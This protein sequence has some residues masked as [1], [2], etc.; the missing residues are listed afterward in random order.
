MTQHNIR[1]T[2]H[3]ATS[4]LFYLVL[5]TGLSMALN[6]CAYDRFSNRSPAWA[7]TLGG[8][9][10]AIKTSDNVPPVDTKQTQ[11]PTDP[12]PPDPAF[13]K[14]GSDVLIK[15]APKVADARPQQDGDV[16]LNFQNANLLEVIK[17][18]LGDM[19]EVNYT[20]DPTIQGTVS[21]QT[22][23][24]LHRDD[25]IPTLEMLL[26]MNNAALI[27]VD[28]AFR[29]VPLAN[30]FA[31]VRSPQLGDSGLAL[32]TGYSVRV[33]PLRY[34]AAEE[35]AQILNPFVTGN[36]QLLRVDTARNMLILAGT[37]ADMERLLETVNVFDVDRMSGMSVA[38]FTPDFVDAKTLA[39]DLDALLADPK[40]GLMAGLVRFIVVERL[41]GLMVV[42]PRAEY[43]ARVREWV[44]RLD[45]NTGDA[46]PRLFIYRVQNGKATD[47]A[48]VLSGLFEGADEQREPVSLAPGSTPTTVGSDIPTVGAS[49]V[50]NTSPDVVDPTALP[51]NQPP[52]AT[53]PPGSPSGSGIRFNQNQRV[54][55][56]ADEANN[57]LLILARGSE[58]RQILTALKQLDVAPMQVLIEVTI[59]EV[60]LTDNLAYGVEWFFKNG[61]GSKTGEGTLDLGTLGLNDSQLGFTYVVRD[62]I[63]DP[64]AI[65]NLLATE[66]NLSVISSP[67]LLVLNNQEA[68]IQVGDEVPISTQ[69]QQA[70]VADSNIINSIEYRNTGI[71]LK[72]KPRINSGGLVIMEVEQEASQVPNTNNA[73]PL[74]PRIQ[75]RKIAST[76]AINSGDT[77][78]LGGLIQDNRNRSESGIPVAH[79][80]PILGALFGTKAD[81]QDRT[82]LIVL[83]T[84]RAVSNSTA[85]LQVTEEFRRRLQKLIPAPVEESPKDEPR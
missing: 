40:Q 58:Y 47:M 29:V 83:I 55:I 68:S 75:Q 6:G 61:I 11:Q 44:N 80:I 79:K 45:R 3:L 82:E 60:T 15:P 49:P 2:R 14:P 77:I 5:A 46:S 84:P 56:I 62:S 48:E 16:K 13:Y 54:Q 67:S 64:R 7:D 34:V 63:G 51:V 85:A 21:M 57:A 70:T 30:A 37:A 65:L 53:P 1:S 22:T 18:I 78:V 72:V 8:S 32:P 31:E 23:R 9:S 38:L 36:N 17:V 43:L 52:A 39:A 50:T 33:V 19:L 27:Q 25:L 69:Q 59:A 74:T 12:L 71:L 28:G 41:N 76:V 20:V 66:S 26:R 10:T 24:A 81:N 35:M 42:T 73:D 4:R